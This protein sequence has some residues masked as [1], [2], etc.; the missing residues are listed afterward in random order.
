MVAV[1]LLVFLLIGYFLFGTEIN[2]E[3]H[4]KQLLSEKYGEEF[5]VLDT[6]SNGGNAYFALCYPTADRDLLF[7]ASFNL[8]SKKFRDEYPQSIVS[9]ELKTIVTPKLNNIFG[10]CYSC[11]FIGSVD[12]KITNKSDVTIE[13]FVIKTKSYDGPSSFYNIA[14]NCNKLFSDDFTKEYESLTQCLREMEEIGFDSVFHIYFLPEKSYFNFIEYYKT[15]Y[16]V[17]GSFDEI[18]KGSVEIGFGYRDGKLNITEDEYI[19]LRKEVN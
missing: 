1:V 16:Q 4:T 17:R 7:E 2:R 13:N 9:K 15:H 3:K 12:S 6:W 18:I 11:P 19:E 10:E 8:K 5:E 14:V